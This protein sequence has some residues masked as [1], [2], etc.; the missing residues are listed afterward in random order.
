M[1]FDTGRLSPVERGFCRLQRRR[2]EQPSICRNGVAFLD[3][4]DVAGYDLGCG[5]ALPCPLTD[6]FGI[7]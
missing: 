1:S 2:L 4:D 7:G 5:N 6:H 3:E